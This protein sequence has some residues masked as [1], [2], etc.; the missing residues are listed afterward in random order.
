[1]S[2][3]SPKFGFCKKHKCNWINFCVKCQWG[4]E[5][6]SSWTSELTPLDPN[7]SKKI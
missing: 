5:D 6:P 7:V 2:E 1:M 4:D 3:K